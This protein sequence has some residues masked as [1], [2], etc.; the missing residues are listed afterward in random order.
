MA[1]N[2]GAKVAERGEK[3]GGTQLRA[4]EKKGRE[5]MRSPGSRFKEREVRRR[6]GGK[7]FVSGA[8]SCAVTREGKGKEHRGHPF[9]GLACAWNGPHRGDRWEPRWLGSEGGRGAAEVGREVVEEWLPKRSS[10]DGER[11]GS[12]SGIVRSW[13]DRTK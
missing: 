8:W 2:G 9:I 11:L 5:G 7:G 3:H 4:A 10:G 1:G 12:G 6:R 13:F